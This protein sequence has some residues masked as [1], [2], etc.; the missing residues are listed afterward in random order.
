MSSGCAVVKLPQFT[1]VCELQDWRE[2]FRSWFVSS[3]IVRMVVPVARN[4]VLSVGL[5]VKMRIHCAFA[6]GASPNTATT[7]NSVVKNRLSM[8]SNLRRIGDLGC[9]RGRFVGAGPC[10]SRAPAHP[11]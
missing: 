6:P 2:P 11:G 7:R 5:S 1:D 3:V 10:S 9:E 4:F 8:V